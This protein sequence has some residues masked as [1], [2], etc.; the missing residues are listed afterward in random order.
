MKEEFYNF[1]KTL[2]AI[3]DR[4]KDV[5]I[6]SLS[7]GVDSMVLTELLLKKQY[8]ILCVHFNH[9]KSRSRRRIY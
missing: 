3:I 7:G 9:K 5:L 2:D 1:Y 4:K 8:N 6:V